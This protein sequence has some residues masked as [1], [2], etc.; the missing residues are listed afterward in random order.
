MFLGFFMQ[1]VAKPKEIFAIEYD[2]EN[3]SLTSGP[4]E[5]K[6]G[7]II[8]IK[9]KAAD[10]YA[11]NQSKLQIV[12]GS[13][14]ITSNCSFTAGD[15]DEEGQILTCTITIPSA[16][17]KLIGKGEKISI[18]IEA[19]EII[20]DWIYAVTFNGTGIKFPQPTTFR[21]GDTLNLNI[22][23]LD[24]YAI[25]MASLSLYLGSKQLSASNYQ[26]TNE[27]YGYKDQ[28]FGFTLVIPAATT[29][30]AVEGDSLNITLNGVEEKYSN[31]IYYS[32]TNINTPSIK[33]YE[34]GQELNINIIPKD[35]YVIKK[36][37]LVIVIGS[38]TLN[39]NQYSITNEVLG[40]QDQ[41]LSCTINIPSNTTSIAQEGHSMNIQ[42][43]GIAE[44]VA[45]TIYNVTYNLTNIT[46]PTI[47]SIEEKT[48]YQA[49][50]AVK[51]ANFAIEKNKISVT[52]GGKSYTGFTV[53]DKATSQDGA[54]SIVLKVPAKDVLGDIN[55]TME[56]WEYFDVKYNLVNSNMEATT[57]ISVT[58]KVT[59]YKYG[60]PFSVTFTTVNSK[61][62]KEFEITSSTQTFIEG[63]HYTTN[64][65]F[66]NVTIND[67][68]YS[69]LTKLT[70]NI[71]DKD[72]AGEFTFNV[73][74]Q[75]MAVQ[76]YSVEFDV[77]QTDNYNEV[78]DIVNI[79]APISVEKGKTIS[80]SLIN[81]IPTDKKQY[82]RIDAYQ[83]WHKNVNGELTLSGTVTDVPNTLDIIVNS[84]IV[85]KFIVINTYYTVT[86]N[87]NVYW[88]HVSGGNINTESTTKDTYM[89]AKN[90][91]F[92]TTYRFDKSKESSHIFAKPINLKVG[93]ILY[94]WDNNSNGEYTMTID[95]VTSDLSL[96]LSY[97]EKQLRTISFESL[98]N[99]VFVLEDTDNMDVPSAYP[100][101]ELVQNKRIY[102]KEDGSITL[103]QYSN[104]SGYLWPA[105]KA[106]NNDWYTIDDYNYSV[107]AMMNGKNI[108][109]NNTIS[110]P[111]YAASSDELG[112]VDD[113]VINATFMSKDVAPVQIVFN[114]QQSVNASVNVSGSVQTLV[115]NTQT[116]NIVFN[117]TGY[118][119]YYDKAEPA[120]EKTSEYD[121]IT[122]SG[123][124]GTPGVDNIYA[125]L[126]IKGA[127]MTD[128]KYKI[129]KIAYSNDAGKNWVELTGDSPEKFISES[130]ESTQKSYTG[131][132]TS[133]ISNFTI[134]K[135]Y[136]SILQQNAV[137][138][139]VTCDEHSSVNGQKN[140]VINAK[141]GSSLN[142]IPLTFDEY[143]TLDEVTSPQGKPSVELSGGK[144][145]INPGIAAEKDLQFTVKSK[146]NYWTV[147]K[148]VDTEA[149]TLLTSIPDK[150]EKGKSLTFD[151]KNNNIFKYNYS[152][153][154]F[155][156]GSDVKKYLSNDWTE[157]ITNGIRVTI[158]TTETTG[159][160]VIN[161]NPDLKDI[162]DFTFNLS[163]GDGTTFFFSPEMPADYFVNPQDFVQYDGDITK[164]IQNGATV[165][166]YA[167]API[168]GTAYSPFESRGRQW[169][170]ANITSNYDNA[171]VYDAGVPLS[172][173]NNISF[174]TY[175][176]A[177]EVSHPMGY[178][179]NALN[180]IAY[181]SKVMYAIRNETNNPYYVTFGGA[182]P[183]SVQS[184]DAYGSGN[185]TY[186]SNCVA[187]SLKNGTGEPSRWY[188]RAFRPTSVPTDI[189]NNNYYVNQYNNVIDR[190]QSVGSA[191]YDAS[192]FE[193]NEYNEENPENPGYAN[194]NPQTTGDNISYGIQINGVVSLFNSADVL[195]SE[196]NSVKDGVLYGI[197]YQISNDGGVTW[198][199]E[200]NAGVYD[201][202]TP[203][204]PFSGDFA[205]PAGYD[206]I[207][208]IENNMTLGLLKIIIVL[209]PN[210]GYY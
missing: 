210:Y 131:I 53:T 146:A 125:S 76:M 71:S 183:W 206:H 151:V 173:T 166:L 191:G 80:Q 132:D 25:N 3:V 99:A 108:A 193:Y 110:L 40:Y 56:A 205:A 52:I 169:T 59:R 68:D 117:K 49:T 154:Y 202:L 175:L 21:N 157:T 63:V 194:W 89:V 81:V 150:V 148:N 120:I 35:G 135:V 178:T 209:K 83:I 33:T 42:M 36:G 156:R 184:G 196:E 66:T 74:C 17:T 136:V 179:I 96:S 22:E 50:F 138:I 28:L 113:M 18:Y 197:R 123:V 87:K 186:N 158:P 24:G 60:E 198:S 207:K 9:A 51:S 15:K 58:N 187:I 90:G 64:K 111:Y 27:N 177:I 88:S 107:S 140:Y 181:H 105:D 13:N 38:T 67:T 129:T 152:S 171:K 46:A 134:I 200:V 8:T 72:V 104:V 73:Q 172:D 147:T 190:I 98:N 95:S 182:T 37:S 176:A 204:T 6:K 167:G 161:L 195:F 144:Y 84:N 170:V 155:K 164:G 43:D 149:F 57:D 79:P 162:I 82:Y 133:Y 10:G 1:N 44:V 12:M 23:A 101:K 189:N 121:S 61:W 160:I 137:T 102:T 201:S 26:I 69:Y 199:E 86:V 124:T 128:M 77:A 103:Y 16:Q 143:Y 97:T 159:D 208:G 168:I 119:L 62:I 122:V 91:E 185:S 48:L 192:V 55:I 78:K 19:F 47:T 11:I 45:P 41:L 153:V 203:N 92:T 75:N 39:S 165:S 4:T 188:T 54:T 142:W 100:L 180:S 93:E 141:Y 32:L 94:V 29:N 65:E 126:S 7:E 127:N 70:I 31:D 115:N 139:T 174:N 116:A 14:N 30:M 34:P 145:Y 20:E 85:I 163:N 109:S 2:L 118:N 112:L 106:E 130:G 5:F 114:D